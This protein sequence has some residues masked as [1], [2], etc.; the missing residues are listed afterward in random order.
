[1]EN[2]L[3]IIE[4]TLITGNI[5]FDEI[6]IDTRTINRGNLFIPICFK[7]GN[8]NLYIK[9][10]VEKGAGTVLIPKYYL[11]NNNILNEILKVNKDICVIEI[12]DGLE[13]LKRIAKYKRDNYKGKVIGITGSN[14]KTSTKEL[15][16]LVISNKYTCFKSKKNYNNIL[17][18]CMMLIDLKDEE[19]AVFELG[20][21]HLGEV[22]E[23]SKIL[24][25]DIG[26]ITNIGSSHIGNLG[27]KENILKAKLEIIDGFNDN[28]ILFINEE[29]EYLKKVEYKNTYRFNTLIGKVL[30]NGIE[31]NLN[32]QNI[33]LE[34]IGKHNILNISSVFFISSYLGI[35]YE[36]IIEALRKYE[37]VRI[38][39]YNI[40]GCRILDDSYNANY[41]SM[42]NGI[43]YIDKLNGNKILVLGDMLE[44]GDDE[45]N[46]HQLLGKYIKETS[47][48]K[49]YTYG[50]LSKYIGYTCNKISYHYDCLE[51][52]VSE[53]VSD[54]GNNTTIYIKGSN[55]MRM[56]NIVE[57]LKKYFEK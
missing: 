34:L 56:Y 29:D 23:M 4:G 20:M 25:P 2:F 17:G 15:L 8:G 18:L 46:Y 13:V 51:S 54:I 9:D 41:E 57:K 33:Y 44:L 47:I 40:N 53:I 7:E 43:D 5:N 14:G 10:A 12:D 52:L 55:G 3:N 49:V 32:N 38:K 26:L 30:D 50:N 19:Y 27:S 35:S 11:E 48:N 21:N 31:V 37:N 6:S 24:K 36:E 45:I 39:E 22:S 28:G 42:V 16:H 1:M